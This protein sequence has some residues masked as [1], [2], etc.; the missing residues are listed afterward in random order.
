LDQPLDLPEG[1]GKAAVERAMKDRII[2]QDILMGRYE[3]QP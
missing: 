2:D 3:R 1:A